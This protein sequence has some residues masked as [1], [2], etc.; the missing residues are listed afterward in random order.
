MFL[1]IRNSESTRVLFGRSAILDALL[2][3]CKG[4]H[5]LM[6]CRLCSLRIK[7]LEF[8]PVFYG[9]PSSRDKKFRQSFERKNRRL[10][11]RILWFLANRE[12]FP[13]SFNTSLRLRVNWQQ[14]KDWRWNSLSEWKKKKWHSTETSIIAS[15][16]TILEAVNK[17][18]PTATVY[19]DM[20]KAFDSINHSILLRKLKAIGLAPSAVS[21]FNSDLSQRSQ[22]V[23]IMM[24]HSL[25]LYQWCV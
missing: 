22:V 9:E 12:T 15:T 4:W 6:N 10:L 7:K 2:C 3:F 21:W 5:L 23:C 24:L 25:T 20:S 8:L 14:T 17:R 18:K 13:V 1:G 19:L 11:G 16:D